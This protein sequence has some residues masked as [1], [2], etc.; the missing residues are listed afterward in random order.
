MA[1]FYAK[2]HSYILTLYSYCFVSVSPV[3]F[4]FLQILL[5]YIYIYIYIYKIINT[6]LWLGKILAPV[7]LQST[8][9]S[10][11]I[12]I[13]T[14]SGQSES[15]WKITI[16]IFTP[17]RAWPPAINSTLQFSMTFMMKF[18]ISSDILYIFKH[19]YSRLRGHIIGFLVVNPCHGFIFPPSFGFF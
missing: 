13:A 2:F 15:P 11:I 10:N 14:N 3:L 16:W 4:A 18:M 6:F 1:V 12:A 7:H 17:A 19:Y 9:L 8:W 5:C